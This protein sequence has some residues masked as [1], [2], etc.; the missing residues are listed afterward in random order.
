MER[1]CNEERVGVRGF[2]FFCRDGV[3]ILEVECCMKEE[4]RDFKERRIRGGEGK[5]ERVWFGP[6]RDE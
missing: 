2:V 5:S 4:K 6:I 1:K 3:C